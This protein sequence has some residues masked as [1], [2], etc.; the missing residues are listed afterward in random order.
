MGTIITEPISVTG[1]PESR[2][3]PL[4]AYQGERCVYACQQG[5]PM[6]VRRSQQPSAVFVIAAMDVPVHVRA[7]D[8]PV[9]RFAT[10]A[11]FERWSH[12]TSA[13]VSAAVDAALAELQVE[14]SCC[15]PRTQ[16]VLSR[17]RERETIPS[18]KELLAVCSSRRSFYRYWTQDIGETPAAFLTRVRL[19]H[20]RGAA[21]HGTPRPLA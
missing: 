14:A 11:E 13:Q 9:L 2:S 7:A 4:P 15:S 16:E 3:N 17:L 10:S 20:L 6:N 12:E 5:E 1:W 18:V 21:Q 19:L 8:A